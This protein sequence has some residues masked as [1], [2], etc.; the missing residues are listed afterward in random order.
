MKIN[1]VK[2]KN[3]TPPERAEMYS[4]FS[5]Y[6]DNVEH[7]R[8]EN[9]LERKTWI[10]QLR[11]HDQRIVGFS[12]LLTYEHSGSSGP[13]V[14]IYSGDTIIDS[15]YRLNGSL[16]GAFGHFLLRTIEEHRNTSVYWLLT[17]KGVRTYRFLPVFFKD[18]FPVFDQQTP[19]NIK[20]L[21]DEVAEKKF[22]TNYSPDTQ[23]VSHHGKR[24]RLSVSEHDPLLLKRSDPHIDYF[25][26]KNPGYNNGDELVCLTEMSEKNLN[27]RGWRVIKH[28]EV[29]WYE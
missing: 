5:R 28:T 24:D 18:F 7:S 6:Y 27:S 19:D 10:I 13:A 2:R 8:F 22:G 11:N 29:Q 12:T 1:I 23:V 15:P 25:V 14:I 3:V 4:I 9:D 21:I 26:Q 17:T 16:A 20:L